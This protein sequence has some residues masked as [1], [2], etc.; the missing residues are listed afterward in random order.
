[1]GAKKEKNGGDILKWMQ[2]LQNL[3]K[4]KLN[5]TAALHLEKIRERNEVLDLDA[6]NNDHGTNGGPSGGRDDRV[7][8][9]LRQGALELK[10]KLGD[11]VEQINEVLEELRY[12]VHDFE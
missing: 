5:L 7:L 11:C 10:A 6:Y 8:Q 12:I 9:F 3:E 1:M 4:E 2:R